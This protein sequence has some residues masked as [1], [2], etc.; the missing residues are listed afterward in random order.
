MLINGEKELD[1]ILFKE[2]LKDGKLSNVLSSGDIL[3][4][5]AKKGFVKMDVLGLDR[6]G[7]EQGF[8]HTITLQF[9]NLLGPYPYDEHGYNSWDR[10]DLQERINSREFTDQFQE[11]FQRLLVWMP[12]DDPM[13]QGET[14]RFF[15]L[16]KEDIFGKNKYPL[17]RNAENVVKY[18]SGQEY[19]Y[20]LRDK[21]TFSSTDK[22]GNF[23]AV[24][25]Y[26]QLFT[27]AANIELGVAPVCVLGCKPAK[28]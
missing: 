10:S 6:D 12:V 1:W 3:D 20:W 16:S 5:P 23:C 27:V 26:G 22:L 13:V 28:R 24:T 14:N 4:I 7:L 17:F 9:H 25:Y 15:I 19:A 2:M 8:P 11:V 21:D 18:L